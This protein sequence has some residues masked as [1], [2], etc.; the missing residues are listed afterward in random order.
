MKFVCYSAWH[1]LPDSINELFDQANHKSLFFSCLWFETL[2]ELALRE[3]QSL[4]VAC[5]TDAGKIKAALPLLKQPDGSWISLSNYYTPLYTVLLADDKCEDLLDCLVSGLTQLPF[6]H[7]QIFPVA[8][9]D[10]AIQQLQNTLENHSY[11]CERYVKF[12]N[13]F[14]RVNQQSFEQYFQERPGKVRSTIARKSRK[15]AREHQYSIQLFTELN[16]QQAI[17]DYNKIYQ[18]SWKANEPFNCFIEGL[19]N[20]MALINGL[21]LAILYVNHQPVAGQIWFVYQ[22]TAYVFRLAYDEAWKKYSPGSIL[23]RY[24]MEYVIDTDKVDEI[25]YLVGN[26]GYKQ[27]WM[28]ER[29]QRWVLGCAKAN[30]RQNLFQSIYRFISR[31]NADTR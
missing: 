16:A 25:D 30:K 20:R 18:E 17:D 29:R 4:L 9:N 13:W 23:T 24:L 12:H 28:T 14:H 11:T 3:D 10:Q 6:S 2:V 8:E 31:N 19:V 27:D 21:R 15:F 7:L 26:E 1:Q 22:K 5:V